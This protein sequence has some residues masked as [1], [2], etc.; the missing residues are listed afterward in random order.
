MRFLDFFVARFPHFTHVLRWGR[1][2]TDDPPAAPFLPL[3][4]YVFY[5]WPPEG[6]LSKTNI[7]YLKDYKCLS[8]LWKL[9]LH[10]SFYIS[11]QC[12]F[13]LAAWT[14]I[15]KIYQQ[16]IIAWKYFCLQIPKSV[17]FSETLVRKSLRLP[18]STF[19]STKT[20]SC[21]AFWVFSFALVKSF[22]KEINCRLLL[23]TLFYFSG[24]ELTKDVRGVPI[25]Y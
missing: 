9:L 5:E 17:I 6:F 14:D 3:P 16:P 8:K 15:M 19:A 7:T 23:S 18:R 12:H 13:F 25:W 4:L 11:S 1:N 21:N 24:D 10:Q 22:K 2:T 20:W